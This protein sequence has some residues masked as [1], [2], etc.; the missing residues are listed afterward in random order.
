M[1]RIYK[2]APPCYNIHMELP[3]DPVMLMS[4]L[5]TKLRDG[6][7]DLSDLCDAL[8][9]D[10]ETLLL[11]LKNAGLCYEKGSNRVEFL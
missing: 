6:A 3:N 7:D 10:E 5:N 4:Y 1:Q 8:D 11:R 9:T 2:T